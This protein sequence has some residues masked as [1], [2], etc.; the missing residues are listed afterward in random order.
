MRAS[1]QK[2]VADLRAMFSK[3]NQKRPP[4]RARDACTQ[5]LQ[6]VLHRRSLA[7]PFS[8]STRQT[9]EMEVIPGYKFCDSCSQIFGCS[10]ADGINYTT[11]G[12]D[13]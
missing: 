9:M 3:S 8:N 5:C 1:D 4:I 6:Q 12:C 11:T 10:Y 13:E 2:T 7:Q